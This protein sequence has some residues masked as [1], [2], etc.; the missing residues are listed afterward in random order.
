MKT[1]YKNTFRAAIALAAFAVMA[2]MMPAHAAVDLNNE[3]LNY[4]VVYQWGPIWKHAAN[5]TLS[6][7]RSG[8]GYN[9]M[10]VGQTR[11][12]A[13]KV[14][15]VR[16]TL[17]CSLNSTLHPVKYEKITH[18]KNY[19]ARDVVEFSYNGAAT[20]GKCTRIRPGK[21]TVHI[22]L[23]SSDNAYDMLSV[24]YMLR[25]MKFD[26]MVKNAYY[27]TTIFSGKKK[28]S[29]A[30]K[31]LGTT[32]VKMRNGT[33]RDAIRVQFTFTTENGKHSSDGI[34]AY[35]STDAQHIPLVLV[36]KLPVG[37]VKVYYKG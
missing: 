23:H 11:S 22:T 2:S 29:L 33:K 4:E 26:S 9:A 12:W 13:D 10:L 31:Y 19:Y 5:A 35:L 15:P 16:D 18:E 14:Y 3:R 7:K 8:D 32:Q 28:E 6:I 1:W 20:T 30:I 27:K 17:K 34:D 37:E 25:R 36:G 21:E 24:F